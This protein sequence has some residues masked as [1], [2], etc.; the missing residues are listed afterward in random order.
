[1]S[2]IVKKP[3]S[4]PEKSVSTAAEQ[5]ETMTAQRELAYSLIHRIE[6]KEWNGV[7]ASDVPVA[8]TGYVL[9]RIKEK[10]SLA[11]IRK[12]LGI[13]DAHGRIWRKILANMGQ[14]FRVDA[15]AMFARWLMQQES[16]SDKMQ[17]LVEDL[18]DKANDA[19]AS[20]KYI[21][22]TK[23][24]TMG[25]DALNR[26]RQG[27]VKLGKELGVFADPSE[28][29]GG[30]GVT[31]VVQNS[32]KLPNQKDIDAKAVYQ[33]EESARMIEESRRTHEGRKSE[34]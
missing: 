19:D 15:P 5:R 14:N 30:Q 17:D 2:L 32:V 25:I 13:K 7:K 11:Q 9:E 27:T 12:E 29:A 3:G 10:A 18:L 16:L 33:Q 23:E 21:H 34:T 8:I 20:K 6:P 4:E 24:L 22:L 1:M 26:L 31:I 28:R